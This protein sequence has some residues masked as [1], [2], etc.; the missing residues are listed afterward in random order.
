MNHQ[1]KKTFQ[2]MAL[3]ALLLLS[4]F[5]AQALSLDWSGNYRFEY[6]EIDKTSLDDPKMRKAYVLNHLSLSP[7]IIAADGVNIVAKFEVLPNELYPASQT[8]QP[9]GRR[10]NRASATPTSKDDSAVANERHA[11]STFEVSQLYLNVN[12]EYGA[13]VA[14]RAPLEFGLGMSHSAGNGP[15]D[16]WYDTRD[17]VGYKFIIGNFSL[18]PIVGK[19]YDY[20]VGQGLEVQDVIWDVEYNNPETES[21][22]GIFHQTRSGSSGVNDAPA[23][24]F[25]G[26]GVPDGNWNTQHINIFLSRGFDAVKFKIEAGFDSGATGI[27]KT[28]G[29]DEVKL[30][31]YGIAAELDFPSGQSKW[32]WNL[33][34]GLASG[35]N[36]STTNYEGFHFDRNYDVAFMMFNHPL[37]R[38]DLLRTAAQR[39]PNRLNCT[40]DP[41]GPYPTDEA[42]DEE[43]VSNTIYVSPKIDY[44]INDK[45]DWTNRVTWAQLQTNPLSDANIDVPKDL[46]FEWDIGVTFKPHERIT[47][48]NELGLLFPGAAW[49]GGTNNY[50]K[51]F[52]YGFSSKAAISF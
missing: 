15:F 48:S 7:K 30:N 9:F 13:L 29:G 51:G 52:T 22:I 6:T 50:G 33:R 4:S 47:W 25:G 23:K 5:Q 11:G 12:Q 27:R 24:A 2:Q 26:V 49:Q 21:A 43:A 20:S 37:G 38:Y 3:P 41:C 10:P 8:G 44:A 18:M 32:H 14:G 1:I 36:P 34:T 19:V 31:G 35:D 16:H 40:A 45:L 28:V 42:L 17:L 46:G 39:S